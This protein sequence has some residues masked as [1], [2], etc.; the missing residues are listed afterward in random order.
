MPRANRYFLPGYPCHL[1]HRCHDRE[2]LLRFK[3]VRDE[4]RRRLRASLLATGV[5][6][7]SYSITSNHV[8]LVTIADDLEAT[9]AF[10]Q[11]Q[12]GEFAEWYNRTKRRSGA[13]WT[14]RYHATMIE[15]EEHLWRCI[16]YADLNMVRAG[17]VKHPRQWRW[18]GYDE[19]VGR[20]KRYRL[21][22]IPRLLE[23]SGCSDA[24]GL[25]DNYSAM[26]E[27]AIAGERLG[28]E[29]QWTESIAVGSREFVE[30]VAE[31]TKSRYRLD[32]ADVGEDTWTVRE[33]N[34]SYGVA[35]DES[36]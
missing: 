6:L 17:V 3:P 15:R 9:S 13:V 5:S 22:D 24:E 30:E 20:R 18:C 27:E 12:Q 11:R 26:I 4:Y 35:G 25:G 21:L 7:L 8:H 29:A 34:L 10:M 16:R 2:W 33:A 28:R 23:L 1:T 32:L 14:G 36:A 31:K 19:L